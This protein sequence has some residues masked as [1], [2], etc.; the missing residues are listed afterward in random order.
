MNI[1]NFSEA[2]SS[3]KEVI[4]RVV[5]DADVTIITRRDAADAVLMSLDYYNSLVETVHL[6]SSPANA[7]HLAR[8]VEQ[9]SAA[10]PRE[11]MDPEREAHGDPDA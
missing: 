8:S 10:R 3:L 6:L 1:I 9:L 7:V 2:R 4:D 11:L 5:Q